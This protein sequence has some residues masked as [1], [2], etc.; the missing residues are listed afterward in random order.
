MWVPEIADSEGPRYLALASAISQ[1]I[2]SGELQP[3]AKLPPQRDLARELKVTVGTVGR[4]YN[5]VRERQLLS[6]QVGRGTFV[7]EV[8]MEEG[9]LSPLPERQPGTID[10]ACF[11]LSVPG[12]VDAIS[13][14]M[15]NVGHR[16]SLMPLQKYAPAVG[17]LPHRTAG[18]AW[19][20]RTGLNAAPELTM[21][22]NGAHQALMLA[23]TALSKVGETVLVEDLTYSGIKALGSLLERN[24]EGVAIDDKGVIPEELDRRIAETGVRLVYMQPTCH[25]PTGAVMTESRRREIAEIITSH[26]VIAIEDDG[27]IGGLRNRPLP[28]AHFAPDNVIYVTGLSKSVSPAM[29]VGYLVS[30]PKLF[31]QLG[32]KLHALTLANPPLMAEVATS[33]I[34]EGT[35]ETI[36]QRNLEALAARHEMMSRRLKNVP[37]SSHPAAFFIW[38][39]LPD[40]WTSLEYFEAARRAGVSTVPADNFM[41]RPGAKPAVRISVNPWQKP[42]LVKKGI[43][44]LTDLMEERNTPP[45]MV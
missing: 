13:N 11:S 32:T 8:A 41:I 22:C 2:E 5:I 38:V 14:A 3:G 34:N 37:H 29:R 9:M 27:A 17:F 39:H 42:E 43:D 12:L 19:I 28:L 20:S 4:A 31:D 15:I 25:N 16:S 44:I 33:L 30:P 10:F 1:A 45:M 23:I 35:A 36:A 24:L 26:G 18:A 21:V 7:R 40:H 6:S